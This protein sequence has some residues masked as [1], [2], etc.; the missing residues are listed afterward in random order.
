MTEKPFVQYV[1]DFWSP[2]S[3][4]VNEETGYTIAMKKRC[5]LVR[6]SGPGVTCLAIV[7]PIQGRYS[8]P[9]QS[10]KKTA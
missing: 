1:A 6:V 10:I 2:N 9:A 3:P 8:V 5:R 7:R 4:Y